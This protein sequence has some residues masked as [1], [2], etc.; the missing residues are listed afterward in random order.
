[1]VGSEQLR[2]TPAGVALAAKRGSVCR[3]EPIPEPRYR[4]TCARHPHETKCG[5]RDAGRFRSHAPFARRAYNG[6]ARRGSAHSGPRCHPQLSPRRYAGGL[7]ERRRPPGRGKQKQSI[8]AD[9]AT[10]RWYLWGKQCLT[11]SRSD[12]ACS[13]ASGEAWH[14]R[15]ATCFVGGTEASDAGSSPAPPDAFCFC[16]RCRGAR[17]LW[18]FSSVTRSTAAPRRHL[19]LCEW[20]RLPPEPPVCGRR[21]KTTPLPPTA[22]PTA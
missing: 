2:S 19:E 16:T 17:R 6:P 7:H 22:I 3:P 11:A 14:N 9:K 4:R 12:P 20:R 21:R 13:E 5:R 8:E 1:M 15:C 18:Q 10:P